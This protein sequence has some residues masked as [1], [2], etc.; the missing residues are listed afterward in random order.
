MNYEKRYKD[1]QKWMEGVYMELSHERQMEAEAFFPELKE[2][3][4]DK[5]RKDII[6]F[7]RSKNGYMN[8]CEDWDFHNRWIPWLEKQGECVIDCPQNHQDN[9]RPSGGIVLEDFNCGEGFYK[10]N[11]AYLNEKQVEE[12]EEMV[13]EWNN[14]PS[15]SEEDIKDCIG[16][17]LTDAD[18]QR[19]KN[20]HT[21]LR[22][23][24]AWLEQQDKAF[25]FV[26]HSVS[27]EPIEDE[28][29]LVEW[30]SNDATWH[31]IAFYHADTKTFW[32]DEKHVENVTRW[33]YVDDLLEKQCEQKPTD[34]IEPKFKVGDWVVNNLGHTWHIDSLDKKNYQ[35][36]DIYGMHLYFRISNQ[37]DM[38]IWTTKD[39][40]DGDVLVSNH[41]PF[42][43]NGK[44]KETTF[45]A[46]CGLNVINSFVV[47][48][49]E[50]RWTSSQFIKP[51]TKEQKDT[52]IKKMVEAGY[53]FDFDKKELKKNMTKL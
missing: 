34:N 37:D 45:G 49:G 19:F 47:S 48:T 6:S 20:Y 11:L 32:N 41:S 1:A 29:L 50:I 16:L 8:P 5:I 14:E 53:I 18:E 51:A 12:V 30:E 10:R 15:T 40:K 44:F 38:H 2:S 43:Y 28:E 3:K 25:R 23:C 22:D 21:N 35:V 24:L 13:R 7:L 4:D 31:D 33:C 36:S 17:C 26:W 42:I 27:E 9:N 52:L 46:Y 39:A